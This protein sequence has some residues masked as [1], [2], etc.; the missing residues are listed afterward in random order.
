VKRP[1]QEVAGG[2]RTRIGR[3][4]VAGRS[5]PKQLFDTVA[6]AP[7]LRDPMATGAAG[8]MLVQDFIE[9][10]SDEEPL[11]PEP[12]SIPDP[13]FVDRLRSR[14]WRDHVMARLRHLDETH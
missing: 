10:L 14:L 6:C 2:P 11:V 5:T 12:G 3:P 1:V 4:D 13:S 8:A 9:F 7:D